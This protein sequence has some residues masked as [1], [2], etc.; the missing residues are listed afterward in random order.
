VELLVEVVRRLV[1][2]KKRTLARKRTTLGLRLGW[3]LLKP[4]VKKLAVEKDKRHKPPLLK[5]E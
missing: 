3:I 4:E 1:L 5:L 2:G